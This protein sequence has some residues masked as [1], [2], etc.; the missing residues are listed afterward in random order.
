MTNEGLDTANAA[1]AADA[2]DGVRWKALSVIAI[3]QFMLVLDITVVNVALPHIQADL[4]FS[5]AG[6]AWVVDGYVLTAG[7]L[8]LLGG[9]LGDLLGRKRM[10]LIGVSI[11]AIASALSGAAVDPAMLVASR[12]AQ[13][14]GEAFAGPASFGLIALLFTEPKERAKAIGIFGGV[15]GLG[16]TLG[17]VISGLLIAA[18]S[19]RWIFFV[20][21]PVALF[22]LIAV[23]RLVAESRAERD[24][25]TAGNRPDVAG[26]VLATAG[27]C[28]LVY[29]FISAGNHAWGS[30]AVVVSLSAGVVLLALFV[31]RERS[32][33]A[34]L[35]PVGFLNNRTRVTANFTC[36]FFASVFF[37]MFFLLTLYLQEVEHYSA[38]RT[39][40]SY[41]PFGVVIGMGI[42]FSS[43]VV[44][45]IGVKVLLIAGFAF[46]AVGILLM[47]R[48]TVG[49]SYV[50]EVLPALMV[51]AFGSGICFASFGNA[52]MHEVSGQDASLASGM[53]SVAQQIGGA[54]GL[55]VLSTIAL[56]RAQSEVVHGVASTVASTDGAALAFRIGAVIALIGGVIVAVVRFGGPAESQSPHLE[57][58]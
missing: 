18:G 49:G 4:G 14:V 44:H 43:S 3:V 16:G 45:K 41:L 6:L 23:S 37:T 24:P 28:G 12:F 26:A 29:G 52:S 51:M 21:V 58:A 31:L 7:G 17:P 27:L 15:A 48:I 39:G 8:I 25:L 34:P 50:T 2:P 35:V 57:P 56:R 9:R 19:W 33:K 11:F 54:L 36:L 1:P 38:I 53:Q 22:A 40:L 30:T 13:G 32:A 46:M 55:A 20:N 42:G 47:S 10:F 5:R